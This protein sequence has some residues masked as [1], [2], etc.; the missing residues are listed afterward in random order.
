MDMTHCVECGSPA[1][2]KPIAANWP[3]CKRCR[4]ENWITDPTEIAFAIANDSELSDAVR[5]Q[6]PIQPDN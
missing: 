1:D 3:I 2:A 6:S 4:A 5:I